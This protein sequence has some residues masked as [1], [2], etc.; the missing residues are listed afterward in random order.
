MR[1]TVLGFAGA[2]AVALASPA[3]AADLPPYPD[4]GMTYQ[5]ESH[6][7]EQQYQRVAPRVV[8]R[9]VVQ[10]TIVVRR[11]IVVTPPHV[12]VEEYPVYAAPIYP[13]IV[14]YG[15]PGLRPRYFGPAPPLCWTS[16]RGG[17]RRTSPVVGNEKG[18]A[19]GLFLR[20]PFRSTLET[21]EPSAL[22]RET[23]QVRELSA[24]GRSSRAGNWSWSKRSCRR[25][26][27][28][29]TGCQVRAGW[30]QRYP[31]SSHRLIRP[32]L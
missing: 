23:A 30:R 31:P 27:L 5:R 21:T 17:R 3:L 20:S 22:A 10:E 1:N 14:A 32:L 8:H 7:Y 18:P 15:G 28:R 19:K 12:V 24:S 11:P 4:G 26:S 16:L 25:G 6:T 13:P 9:P 29:R 2:A